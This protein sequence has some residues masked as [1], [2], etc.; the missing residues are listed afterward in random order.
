LVIYHKELHNISP[1]RKNYSIQ[2][3]LSGIDIATYFSV[4]IELGTMQWWKC[5]LITE[6]HMPY[7]SSSLYNI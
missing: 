2:F 3:I 7:A 6:K 4:V 5:Y 1:L